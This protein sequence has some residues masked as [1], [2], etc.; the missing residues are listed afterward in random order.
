MTTASSFVING[1]A[2]TQED[3]VRSACDPTCSVV[4]EAC[5]GSGKTFLL[6]ARM[7]RLLLEGCEPSE[8]LAITFTRKAA[9]EMRER[10]LSL[11][12]ELALA[13]ISVAMKLL[14]ERGLSY[15]EAEIKMPQA[16]NL[17]Q[18]VLSSPFGL[19]I[20]TFHSWFA[21]LLQIA[22]LSSGVPHAYALEDNSA[23]LLNDAWVRFMHSLNQPQQSDLR[24]AL[25]AIYEIAGDTTGKK[26]IDA[27]VARRAEWW[28]ATENHDPL[29]QLRQLCGDDAVVDARLRLWEDESLCQRFLR[30]SSL[31]GKGTPAQKRN[32][33]A[34]ESC[35][36][37]GA[38]GE[39]FETL[40]NLL[41]TKADT[42][43]A[44]PTAQA[45]QNALSSDEWD[46]YAESWLALANELI[47]LR[48]RSFEPQV[49]QLNEAVFAIGTAC[50]E[51]YQEIKAD[52]RVLDFSD[53]EWFT[54][55]LLTDPAHAAYMQARLDARYRHILIDEFQDT[56]PLQWQIVRAWLDAYGEEI[57]HPTVFIVGDPKQSIY[58]FR[59]AEPRV[60]QSAREKLVAMGA[61]D[62]ATRQTHRNA[63]TIVDFLNQSMRGNPLYE[64]Q[65]TASNFIGQVWRLPL[66][67]TEVN[68]EA[69]EQITAQATEQAESQ[70]ESQAEE[71]NTDFV[72]RDPLHV[73]PTA[74]EDSRRIVE[75]RT[76]GLA[77]HQARAQW[78][79]KT[80][81]LKWSQILILVRSR[82]HLLDYERGLR[83]AGIP[84]VSSRR[85]GL[86]N[87]LEVAD[88]IALLR[89]LTVSAD[90]HALAHVLKSPIIGASD[91]DLIALAS[92]GEGSWWERL[93]AAQTQLPPQPPLNATLARAVKLLEGWQQAAIH[94]P[95]HDL[96]DQIL[97]EGELP[98]RYASTTSASVRAQVMGNLYEFL[99]LAL[100]LDAGRYPSIAR[101]LDRLHKLQ[102]SS[103]QDAPDEAA[104]DAAL[105]AVRIMT[106][107]GAKGLE[108][109]VVVMLDANNSDS[110]RDDLGVLCEW[111]QDSEAPTHLSVFGKTKERGYARHDLFAIEENFRLQENWNLLYVAI[112]RAKKILIVS[113]IHNDKDVE[114]IT[115]DSWYQKFS[116]VEA[117]APNLAESKASSDE[118]EFTLPLFTPP[119]LPS[120]R[121]PQAG[122]DDTEATLEGSLLHALMERLTN[123]A[124]WPVVVPEPGAVANWL[125]CT[126]AQ[127]KI[128]CVQAENI[129]SEP[130]LKQFYDPAHFD[131]ARN[132]M[133]LVHQGQLLLIDRLVTIGE[134][135]WVLDYK[136]N[137]LESQRE[138]YALQLSRYREACVHLFPGKQICT[139]LITVDGRLWTIEPGAGDSA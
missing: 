60:F 127:A 76:V 62:L 48:Q 113:G 136:R 45:L 72:L 107:H 35:I 109:E 3:F 86:L 105:D 15:E 20:D 61:A 46:W 131:F 6:V 116:F 85:G 118:K 63:K 21:R 82:T 135:V 30:L 119:L 66:A 26:L 65:T 87:A 31:L 41:L 51:H 19:S 16:R 91:D 74:Q 40:Y 1:S 83:E 67:T 37:A 73:L 50:L 5:A 55:K 14:Q 84:F 25:M 94:L 80:N 22:P 39:Q 59:R 115:A 108:A 11:L 38:S 9:A 117:V 99:A 75:A 128:I 93:L 139:A 126:S 103:D 18:R 124:I 24:A 64:I 130:S 13:E 23:E 32:A 77:L 58:R 57:D 112:T 88:L 17:Y 49:I 110:Q 69:T 54:W 132:E 89:W 34:I 33:T 4:V 125:R 12:K 129:L 2:R 114:G 98:A 68:E 10:L 28:V 101:F 7:L 95:V 43:R 100:D 42:P 137:F 78:E 106:I 52:R 120:A 27:F 121:L 122:D 29:E 47:A 8:L 138:D 71:K 81:P 92:T 36:T 97:H 90:N 123:Q 44:L 96:L 53:L 134:I 56:N 70:A 133:A 79:D 111:P 102:R 104:I